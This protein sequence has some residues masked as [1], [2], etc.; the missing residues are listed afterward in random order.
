[1]NNLISN[2]RKK[3]INI[4]LFITAIIL[5]FFLF[6]N[7]NSNAQCS[8]VAGPLNPGTAVIAA[9]AGSS[10]TFS[11]PSNVLASDGSYAQAKATIGLFSGTTDYI[12]ATNFNFSSAGIPAGSTVCGIKVDIQKT[13]TSLVIIIP[14]AYVVDDKVCLVKNGTIITAGN[15]ALTGTGNIWTTTDAWYSY[16]SNSD[17]WGTTW[18]LSDITSSNFGVAISA[19]FVALI[20][21]L[22]TADIDNIQVTVYYDNNSTLPIRLNYFNVSAQ[23]SQ[24]TVQWSADDIAAN[25]L[26]IIERSADNVLW[27]PVDT[28]AANAGNS[29]TN[30]YQYTDKSPLPGES[31]YRLRIIAEKASTFISEIKMIDMPAITT[32]KLYPNPASDY[33]ILSNVG[34]KP[35]LF[36]T[37]LSGRICNVPYQVVTSDK[38]RIDVSGLS[39]GTYFVAVNSGVY[40]F[41]KK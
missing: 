27:Q 17:S 18:I 32:L 12:V 7:Y 24:A 4:R 28:V 21:L 15:H 35:R 39:P 11:S 10:Y 19:K 2:A 6:V 22:P 26:F 8:L 20:A 41:M 1:M 34:D 36:V 31:F 9:N 25:S 5:S 38:V 16:G 23:N 30:S 40:S 37:D 33:I 14:T 29:L 3:I 13:G